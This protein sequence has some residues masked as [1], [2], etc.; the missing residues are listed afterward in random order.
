MIKGVRLKRYAWRETTNERPTLDLT[1][2]GSAGT[3]Q[4]CFRVYSNQ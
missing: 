1:L 4:R 2:V 3:Y